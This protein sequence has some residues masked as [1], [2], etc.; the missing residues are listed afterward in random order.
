MGDQRHAEHPIG[1]L[2]H[3][4]DRARQL[5][6]TAL[7]AA[8]GVDLRLDHPGR[9]AKG[10]RGR[11]GLV[12]G[13]GDLARQHGDSVVLEQRLGLVFVNVHARLARRSGVPGDGPSR[14]G[15]A[16]C[17][18]WTAAHSSRTAWTDRSNAARSSASSSISTI[19]STP[20]APITTGTPT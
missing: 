17:Y 6:A 11:L 2:A 18:S 7:A 13:I 19:R 8:A 4:L 10:A 9:S 5:D 3:L 20:P 14:R 16:G 12:G 15:G 1:Q